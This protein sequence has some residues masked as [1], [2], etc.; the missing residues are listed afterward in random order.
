MAVPDAGVNEKALTAIKTLSRLGTVRAAYLFGSR[1]NSRADE[2]SDIDIAVFMDGFETWDIQRA[3]HAMVLVMEEAGD[4]VEV[5]FFPT[6]VLE[7]PGR[8]SFAEYVLQHGIC[9]SDK[10]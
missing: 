10:H 4:D 2:W 1:V 5:H 9:L 7:H 6:S 3:T 8:G